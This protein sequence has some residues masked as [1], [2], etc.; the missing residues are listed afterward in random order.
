MTRAYL[1]KHWVMT[2]ILAPF[3]PA[4]YE[5]FFDPI[6]GQVIGLLKVYPVIFIFSLVFSIPTL[7]I[8]HF[9]FS[10]LIKRQTN[11]ALTKTILIILTILG[12]TITILLIGGSLSTTLIYSFS[13]A[14][15]MAGVVI[16][17]TKRSDTNKDFEA[18]VRSI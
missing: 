2:L 13:I 1:F 6:K 3:L 10:Y 12:I 14:A 4:I 11:P 5:L 16:R 17:I 9:V 7:I 15:C 8:Y 18:I